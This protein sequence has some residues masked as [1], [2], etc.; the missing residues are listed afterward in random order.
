MNS[1]NFVGRLTR[2][3]ELRTGNTSV[4]NFGLAV[5]RKFKKDGQPTADFPRFVAFGK[6]A[7]IMAQYLS[8]G[9]QVAITGRLQTGSYDD[10]NGNKVYTT[11]IIVESFTFISGSGSD[12]GQQNKPQQNQQQNDLNGFQAIDGDDDIPF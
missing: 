8:K 4:A 11:D 9:N 3:I 2:D 1:C 6:T 5:D 7:E 12:G 10:K